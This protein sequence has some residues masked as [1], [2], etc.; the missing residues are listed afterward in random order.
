VRDPEAAKKILAGLSANTEYRT[1]GALDSKGPV[2]GNDDLKLTY[3][4][5][6]SFF[7]QFP[8][9]EEIGKMEQDTYIVEFTVPR[10][11]YEQLQLKR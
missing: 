11:P 2:N 10:E 4:R 8:Y 6:S 1:I 3:I 5:R 9:F 7:G